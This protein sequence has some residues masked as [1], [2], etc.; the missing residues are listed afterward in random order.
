[1]AI[2]PASGA[3]MT[4][5]RTP[6]QK[7]SVE[8]GRMWGRPGEPGTWLDEL[9]DLRTRAIQLQGTLAMLRKEI[10]LAAT[11]PRRA[12]VRKLSPVEVQ[13]MATS[14]QLEYLWVHMARATASLDPRGPQV[15]AVY[16]RPVCDLARD[17]FEALLTPTP[18][19]GII[20]PLS[21][22]LS[23]RI[24]E[25]E[26]VLRSVP[27]DDPAVP[28]KD[29]QDESIVFPV[30]QVERVAAALRR[31]GTGAKANDIVRASKPVGRQRC[32]AIRRRLLSRTKN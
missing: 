21:L 27:T 13:I 4:I 30:E 14:R 1:M 19:D 18:N 25:L 31:L 26:R 3:K 2:C 7:A 8:T 15:A 16:A 10:P 32:L 20:G 6:P 12:N 24:E 9:W 28:G 23:R 29:P 5:M 17:R 22:A 11:R